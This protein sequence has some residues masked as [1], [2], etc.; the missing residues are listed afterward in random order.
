MIRQS[1]S[2]K[3][4]LIG[5]LAI[6]L[7]VIA[8]L[9]AL[10]QEKESEGPVIIGMLHEPKILHPIKVP[11]VFSNFVL[12]QIYDP[13]LRNNPNGKVNTNGRALVKDYSV[14]K[15]GLTYV[16]ELK[17]GIRFHNGEEMDAE[18]VAFTLKALMSGEPP[19]SPRKQNYE[20]IKSVEVTDDYELT[21]TLKHPSAPF[22]TKGKTIVYVVPEDYIKK[23]GWEKYQEELIGTGPYKYAK[24][25]TGSY[26]LLERNDNYWRHPAYTKKLK[27]E[28][29]PEASTAVMALR[30]GKIHFLERMPA[31]QWFNL[32]EVDSVVTRSYPKMAVW[33]IHFNQ[34]E[35]P[36]NNVKVR[37]AMAY[38]IDSK[39]VIAA[40]RTEELANNTRSPVPRI[41][42]AHADVMQYE[43]DIEKAKKLLKEAGYDQIETKLYTTPGSE[44]EEQV[45]Q[46]QVQQAGFD[47][48][49]VKMDVG[50]LFDAMKSGEAPLSHTGVSAGASAHT[51]LE[52]FHSGSNWNWYGGWYKNEKFNETLDEAFRTYDPEKR[53][54]LYKECQRI[55]VNQ[56]M[57]VYVSYT[58]FASSAYY[59][60]LHIPENSWNPYMISGPIKRAYEWYLE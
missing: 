13:L 60:S 53:R 41:N 46:K 26:I 27:F 47:I 1:K 50:S 6:S 31:D 8:G 35:E 28:F 16:F 19:V 3:N 25:K 24:H 45:I 38:A 7:F 40:H 12:Q 51:L 2:M 37:K 55:L 39:E 52:L 14:S 18:D 5:I 58:R 22:L 32:K 56:D 23:H 21:L 43:Q 10:S 49:L 4:V 11:E 34:K 44:L 42:P 59:K 33:S 9:G 29:Y 15:D 36:F 17:E 48:E 20:V 30:K 54:E 57:G